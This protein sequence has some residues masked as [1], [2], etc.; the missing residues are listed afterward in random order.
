MLRQAKSFLTAPLRRNYRTAKSLY[1]WRIGRTLSRSSD[2]P[3]LILQMGK[4]G[5]KSVQAGLEALTLNRPIF[6]AHFLSPERTANTEEKRRKYFRTS[7]ET[8]LHRPW[9]NEYLL[10]CWHDSQNSR[11][12]KII[13]LVR[14]PIGRN[15]SAFFENLHVAAAGNSGN[16]VISS[17]YYDIAPVAV[18]ID[19]PQILADLFYEKAVH[20]SPKVFFDREIKDIFGIDVLETGFDFDRG[21]EIYHGDRVEL[22]VLKLE[23]LESCIAQAMSEFLQLDDFRL[24]NRNIGAA[25]DYAPLYDVF[26]RKAVISSEYADRLLKTRYM[27]TFYS[28][29]E[30]SAV[31]DRWVRRV[32]QDAA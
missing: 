23:K 26:K 18:C 21:Y 24:I 22:L 25:K 7:Q 13:T 19:E 1:Q 30:I 27:Q 14:E 29:Q 6:H 12:W 31:K 32:G 15:M 28:D 10:R 9:L 20:D 11:T 8:Y 4:V 3:I 16:F 17:D 5:S 2:G